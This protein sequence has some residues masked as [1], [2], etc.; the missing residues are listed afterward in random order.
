MKFGVPVILLFIYL[1]SFTPLKEL[2]RIPILIFHYY[3]HKG[4]N[5]TMSLVEFF[6][7]HYFHGIVLD[8]DLF[9]DMQLPFKNA[10]DFS[11]FPD[12]LYNA[13][14]ELQFRFCECRGALT[15]KVNQY[16]YSYFQKPELSGIFHPPRQA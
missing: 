10:Q 4:E 6:D 2:N 12:C 14:H 15:Q 16:T 8:E 13:T 9:Q 5:Q 11:V 1:F 7:M 3:Q